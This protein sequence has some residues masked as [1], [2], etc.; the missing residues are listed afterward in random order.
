MNFK[1][2]TTLLSCLVLCPQVLTAYTWTEDHENRATQFCNA[3]PHAEEL[4]LARGNTDPE[5]WHASARLFA[6]FPDALKPHPTDAQI[7]AKWVESGGER[8]MGPTPMPSAPAK[9]ERTYDFSEQK[10]KPAIYLPKAFNAMM[11]NTTM[12]E[13]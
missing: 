12:P 6:T 2:M 11:N 1:K 13:N 7:M 4:C 5:Q 10:R 3:H 9:R 8:E